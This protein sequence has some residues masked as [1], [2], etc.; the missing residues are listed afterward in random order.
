MIQ[1]RKF[2]IL[3]LSL[4]N[5]Y[6]LTGSRL[7][8]R[9]LESKV[10]GD[11]GILLDGL[12]DN[13]AKG[14]EDKPKRGKDDD[15]RRDQKIKDKEEKTYIENGEGNEKGEGEKDNN[16]EK[17][18][19]NETKG[20]EGK[21]KKIWKKKTKGKKCNSYLNEESDK[22]KGGEESNNKSRRLSRILEDYNILETHGNNLSGYLELKT[23]ADCEA[24]LSG[25]TPIVPDSSDGLASGMLKLEVT[26]KSED[27]LEL[28]SRNLDKVALTLVGCD[29][30]KL[31][32]KLQ[33]IDETNATL[34]VALD[35]IIVGELSEVS[36][37]CPNSEI[38]EN[39]TLLETSFTIYF[40]GNATYNHLASMAY[41]FSDTVISESDKG[42]YDKFIDLYYVDVIMYDGELVESLGTTMKETNI[43]GIIV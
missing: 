28:M 24:L 5:T 11:N 8:S 1:F 41:S 40:S 21:S 9:R 23:N 43:E 30:T 37:A 25:E 2:A 20:G 4:I 42:E 12:K 13:Q 10:K 26:S 15:V 39:C 32:R 35:G 7:Q 38:K 18:K 29:A 6:A 19:E 33:T 3:I 17:Q 16:V 31:E 34:A 36:N 14:D 22:K 27:A